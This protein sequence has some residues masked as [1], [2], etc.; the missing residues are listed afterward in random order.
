MIWPVPF[1][2]DLGVYIDERL[3][4]DTHITK[5]VSSCFYQLVHVN[6]IKHLLD[7]QTLLLLIKCFMFSKLFYCSILWSN[8]SKTNVHKPQLVQN[9][10]ARIILGLRKFDH[11]SER[12]KSLLFRMLS[13]KDRLEINDAVMVFKCLNNLVPKYLCAKV[14]M[15]SSVSTGATRSVNN[16]NISRCRLATGQRRFAYRGVKIWNGLSKH[17]RTITSLDN[18][19]QCIFREY[20]S[21]SR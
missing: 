14:Q 5:P 12:L 18:F 8:T 4:Y 16:L 6:R 7:R 13:V 1:A 20:L 21:K 9:F 3:S 19:K 11:I 15:R 10:V 17:P 2:R